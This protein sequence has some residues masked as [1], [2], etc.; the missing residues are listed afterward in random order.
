[1]SAGPPRWNA[2]REFLARHAYVA[3]A[4]GALLVLTRTVEFSPPPVVRPDPNAHGGAPDPVPMQ[5]FSPEL[6]SPQVVQLR[7]V[8]RRYDDPALPVAADDHALDERGDILS[9]PLVTAVLGTEA[10]VDQ[11]VRLERG[12]LQLHLA[13]R[14][15]PR[16]TPSGATTLEHTLE[17]RSERERW[18]GRKERVVLA[19]SGV[20][21]DL[22][23]RSQ[24]WV[25]AVDD[26]LF[27]LDLEAVRPPGPV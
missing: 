22:D 15:T 7:V 20:L 14:A 1:M 8:L 13:L 19:A 12:D 18:T 2:A 9:S 27:S 17:V 16:L 23:G 11:R 21:A 4:A 26:H 24:R 10:G 5:E 25:F 6:S 3:L